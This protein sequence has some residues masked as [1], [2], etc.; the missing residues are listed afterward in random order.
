[1]ITCWSRDDFVLLSHMTDHVMWSC[2]PCARVVTWLTLDKNIRVRDTYLVFCW[3][4]NPCPFL[5][6]PRENIQVYQELHHQT[7]SSCSLNSLSS[8]SPQS[9][10][11]KKTPLFPHGS[12][13]CVRIWL[14]GVGAPSYLSWTCIFWSKVN[15][16]TTRAQS[17]MIISH[18]QSRDTKVQK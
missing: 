6:T 14:E 3:L 16:M 15:H 11:R 18:D 5:S 13:C 4:Q 12:S 2:D 7:C 8:E 1:M 10:P 9:W 17:H